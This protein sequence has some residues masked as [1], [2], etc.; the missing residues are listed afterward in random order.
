MVGG[1]RLLAAARSAITRSAKHFYAF[2]TAAGGA[3]GLATLTQ[4]G[5]QGVSQVGMQ[6][7]EMALNRYEATW[8]GP[9][10]GRMVFEP[11]NGGVDIS[12]IY[13]GSQEHASDMIVEALR[14]RGIDHPTFIEISEIGDE[15]KMGQLEQTLYRVVE[16][17]GGTV[18]EF[19]QGVKVYNVG[20]L[21]YIRV[22]ISYPT[23]R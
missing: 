15:L 12:Q 5:A 22:N 17:L 13:K 23:G 19:S 18:T 8:G 2:F 21:P 4:G 7:R 20:E 11:V 1:G 9:G 14:D 16:D 3:S 10:Q 6:I